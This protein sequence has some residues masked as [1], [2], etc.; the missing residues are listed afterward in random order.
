MPFLEDIYMGVSKN[1]GFSPQIIHFVIGFS[2]IE[3]IHFGI[4]IYQYINDFAH[5]A[6]GRWAPELPLSPPQFERNSE[7]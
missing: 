1:S 6:L 2:I 7:T 3:F 4:P 5:R